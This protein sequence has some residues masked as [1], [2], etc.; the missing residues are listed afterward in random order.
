MENAL[1]SPSKQLRKS[2][3]I[4]RPIGIQRPVLTPVQNTASFV[5]MALQQTQPVQYKIASDCNVHRATHI[6]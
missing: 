6:L 1:P 2:L 3:T 5:F 4:L